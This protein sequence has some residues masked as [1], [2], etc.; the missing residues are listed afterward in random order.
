MNKWQCF[1]KKDSLFSFK[2]VIKAFNIKSIGLNPF[3]RLNT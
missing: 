1:A 2:Q 3:D